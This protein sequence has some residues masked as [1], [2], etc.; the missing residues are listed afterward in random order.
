PEPDG[1]IDLGVELPQFA[2]GLGI[3]RHHAPEW[4][5]DEHPPI[6]N[7]RG[8]LQRALAP[9]AR[10]LRRSLARVIRP[11]R[12]E[13][14][15]ILTSDL[16]EW[17]PAAPEHVMAIR[18]PFAVSRRLYAARLSACPRRRRC[19]DGHHAHGSHNHAQNDRRI[20]HET[21]PSIETR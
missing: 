4:R 12:P 15:D 5:A 6:R 11:R 2:P 10:E 7:E 1:S 14:R 18:A 17:R 21:T 13:P 19:D 3:E 20:S 9:P 8:Y 16:R